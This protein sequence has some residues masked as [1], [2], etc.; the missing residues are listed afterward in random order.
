MFLRLGNVAPREW[1]VEDH[2]TGAGQYVAFDPP[3]GAAEAVTSVQFPDGV[4]LAEAFMTVTLNDGVWDRHSS[5]PPSWVESDVAA[6]ALLVAS[7]YGCPA[8]EASA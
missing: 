4:A 5:A 6:L 2:Q 3:D 7:N 1:V 8:R